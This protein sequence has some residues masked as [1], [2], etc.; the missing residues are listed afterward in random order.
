M[1]CLIYIYNIFDFRQDSRNGTY[2][3][4]MSF[5][6]NQVPKQRVM[7]L[8][9]EKLSDPWACNATYLS[10]NMVIGNIE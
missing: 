5:L 7:Q 1:I 8:I 10:H 6:V 2:A 4:H 9:Y 3:R